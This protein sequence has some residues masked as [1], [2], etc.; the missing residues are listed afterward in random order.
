[1]RIL[2]V[3]GGM[4][5][6]TLA[7]ELRARGIT[8][9]VVERVPEYGRVGFWIGLY[10]FS[11]NTLRET[12]VY[13]RYEEMS[14][15]IADY[16]MCDAHGNELQRMSLAN[17]LGRIGGSMG[18]LQRADLLNLLLQGAEGTD[19]RM[20]TTVEKLEQRD[21]TV[22]ATLSNGDGLEADLVVGADGM[23]S[24]V[25]SLILGETSSTTG[26]TPRSRGGH[27]RARRSGAT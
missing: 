23:H 25:R 9:T 27:R 8:P 26:R 13:D 7:G 19:L 17:V 10:P 20:G 15:A 11:A 22:E 2:I 18:A 12:G 21:G 16:V 3:G 6:L 14:M 24:Q 1:M 4:A 5:G